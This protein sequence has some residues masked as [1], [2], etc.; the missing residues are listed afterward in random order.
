MESPVCPSVE[1]G[2]FPVFSTILLK[3]F[4]WETAWPDL[5]LSKSL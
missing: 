5:H 3:G 4:K 1:L 2:L